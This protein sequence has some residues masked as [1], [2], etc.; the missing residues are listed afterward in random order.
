MQAWHEIPEDLI[1]N[2]DQTPL[3]YICAGN[4]TYAKKGSSNVPVVG[5]GKKSRELSQL[6]CLDHFFPCSLSIK[7]WPI[8]A[9]VDTQTKNVRTKDVHK[10]T[11]IFGSIWKHGK[12]SQSERLMN[13]P[14]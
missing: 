1:I 3:S 4:R 2:F 7:E 12:T 9:P 5:K 6:L 14:M 13:V 11:F 10:R 8:I